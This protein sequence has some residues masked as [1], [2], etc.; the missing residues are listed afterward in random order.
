MDILFRS[1]YSDLE[2]ALAAF[3]TAHGNEKRL[4]ALDDVVAA[5][6]SL[7]GSVNLSWKLERE[8]EPIRRSL[9]LRYQREVR[10]K[11]EVLPPFEEVRRR[12][13]RLSRD[14]QNTR[15][16]A[17]DYLVKA[18]NTVILQESKESPFLDKDPEDAAIEFLPI[19]LLHLANSRAGLPIF[20]DDGLDDIVVREAGK[21]GLKLGDFRRLSPPLAWDEVC[22]RHYANMDDQP[23]SVR[24]AWSRLLGVRR[25]C[26]ECGE[27]FEVL[28]NNPYQTRHRECSARIRQRRRRE[29]MG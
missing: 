27:D 12:L 4:H 20:E 28:P 21:R 14:S 26:A 19:Q 1:A 17:A 11:Q 2:G 5:E 7:R 24:Q 3:G 25:P 13:G 23:L 22:W 29:K 15:R 6:R 16:L 8:P 9:K 10:E 18:L